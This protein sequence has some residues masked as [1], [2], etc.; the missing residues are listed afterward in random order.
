MYATAYTPQAELAAS[1]LLPENFTLTSQS[2][3][4][5]EI[6]E[7]YYYAE[8]NQVK[9]V[10]EAREGFSC[11]SWTLSGTG[12]LD[13]DGNTADITTG[14][15][16]FRESEVAYGSF[17][18]SAVTYLKDGMPVSNVSGQSGITAA[19]RLCNTAGVLQNGVLRLY[20]GENC[21]AESACSAESESFTEVLLY[22]DGHSFAGEATVV[23]TAS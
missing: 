3:A 23:L 14:I 17:A 20:D 16:L 18:I 15:Y 11:E 19:V 12:L 4:T 7:V 10:A 6:T 22:A 8:G 13:V 5:A 1:T 9:L 2:G 21:I